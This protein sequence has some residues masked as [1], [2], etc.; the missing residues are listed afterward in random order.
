ME[1]LK[2]AFIKD[3]KNTGD[4]AVRVRYGTVASIIGLLINILLCGLKLTVGLLC[5]S[6]T[7]IA[8]AVNNLSDAGSSVVTLIG[9][10]L[11]GKPADNEHPFGHARYEYI[12]AL[13]VSFVVLAIGI[14]LGKSSIEKMIYPEEVIPDI[15][16][17][18]ALAI[19]IIGKVFQMFMYNSFGKSINSLAL[20]ACACDSRNDIVSTLVV[21]A[22]TVVMD[23]TGVMLDGYAGLLV[24]VFIIISSLKLV[25]ETIDPLLGTKPDKDFVNR[26]RSEIMSYDG[27]LG[28]HD[29]MVHTYGEGRAFVMVH[30]EVPSE[31]SIT[32]SH[33]IID[34]IE[35]DFKEKHNIIMS[36]HMDPIETENEFV[37]TLKQD[38]A[39]E[40]AKFDGTLSI[41][42]FRVVKGKKH[43]NVLFDMVAPYEKSI[44]RAVVE[45]LAA[46]VAKECYP[47]VEFH[48]I[49]TI[50]NSY[51]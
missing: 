35:R 13:I 8:D 21:L 24:S 31:R 33:D 2:K 10:K 45:R 26:I 7:I 28:L 20:T 42:D 50:E 34:T 4:S 43:T 30:V 14:M 38:I 16:T 32:D 48:F 5:G 12:T 3:Y 36:I 27:V 9:F 44:D 39:T 29:M 25:K 15:Y 47:D 40:I 51:I 17:Y 23:V 22:A 49:I 41:H 37:N 46:S 19:A 18:I 11:S 1:L 6:I